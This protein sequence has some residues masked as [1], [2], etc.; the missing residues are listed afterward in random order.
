MGIIWYT[1]LQSCAEVKIHFELVKS[2]QLQF[3]ILTFTLTLSNNTCNSTF[4]MGP[5]G[6]WIVTK[7]RP[8]IYFETTNQIWGSVSQSS[9]AQY[10]AIMMMVLIGMQTL[11]WT[12]GVTIKVYCKN[13][14]VNIIPFMIHSSYHSVFSVKWV[15]KWY[16]INMTVFVVRGL[17]IIYVLFET[18]WATFLSV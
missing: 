7:L 8:G 16:D 12:I 11:Y 3:T 4:C 6:E 13:T 14:H 18:E 9:S 17:W 1:T 2:N 15:Q 5:V 10:I